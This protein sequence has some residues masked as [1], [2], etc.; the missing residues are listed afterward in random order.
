MAGAVRT[1]AITPAF[2]LLFAHDVVHDCKHDQPDG[3]DGNDNRYGRSG[4][5]QQTMQHNA[6]LFRTRRRTRLKIFSPGRRVQIFFCF[7]FALLYFFFMLTRKVDFASIAQ[8][9]VRNYQRRCG[10]YDEHRPPPAQNYKHEARRDVRCE[11]PECDR[12]AEFAFG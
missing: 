12:I 9:K 3:D 1:A 11:Q 7:L 5:R 2:A 6:L 10:G 4:S 8:N